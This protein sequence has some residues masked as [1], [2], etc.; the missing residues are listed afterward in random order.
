MQMISKIFTLWYFLRSVYVQSLEDGNKTRIFAASEL[1]T[2]SALPDK[3]AIGYASWDE[4]DDKITTAVEEGVNVVI[5]FAINLLTD[6]SSGAP[7]ITGGP[8]LT[9]V[10]EKKAEYEARGLAT[11]HLISIGGWCVMWTYTATVT[12][13]DV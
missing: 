6:E 4:C 3:L 5:W 9:C 7:V 8:N 12:Y 2:A 10:A 11:T 13:T 1:H